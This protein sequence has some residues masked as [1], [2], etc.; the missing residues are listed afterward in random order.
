MLISKQDISIF[1]RNRFSKDCQAQIAI[2]ETLST[3][4]KLIISN[5]KLYEHI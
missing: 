4:L 5:I 2:L 3:L 1:D